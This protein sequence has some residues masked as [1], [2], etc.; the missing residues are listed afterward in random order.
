[1]TMSRSNNLNR[2]K[3]WAE[4]EKSPIHA[5]EEIS[6]GILA[7]AHGNGSSQMPAMQKLSS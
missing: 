4:T 7:G 2:L 3:R 1:M 6:L 5:A